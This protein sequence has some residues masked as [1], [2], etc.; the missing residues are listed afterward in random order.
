MILFIQRGFDFMAAS[1]NRFVLLNYRLD[2]QQSLPRNGAI[3]WQFQ[4]CF[5]RGEL[6][7][8]CRNQTTVISFF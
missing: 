2:M 6:K 4:G 5:R 8:D 7:P 1:P 3:T